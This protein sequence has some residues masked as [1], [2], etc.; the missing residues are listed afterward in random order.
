MQGSNE[1]TWSYATGMLLCVA[2]S[3]FLAGGFS[4]IATILYAMGAR[5]D[6]VSL[7][8]M[9]FVYFV[10]CLIAG[11]IS[12]LLNP[13]ARSPIGATLLGVIS[14][15]PISLAIGLLVTGALPWEEGE[16]WFATIMVASSLGG[17]AGFFGWRE[18][19]RPR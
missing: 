2:V 7:P 1:T 13:I 15:L 16:G 5:I 14:F 3:L 8:T 6:N 19:V 17:G 10:G 11:V 9:I 18:F 4:V 12:G